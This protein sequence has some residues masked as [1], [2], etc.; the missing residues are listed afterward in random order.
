MSMIFE[1]LLID[2]IDRYLL[3]QSPAQCC[4]FNDEI[5]EGGCRWNSM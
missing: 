5:V 2:D 4:R 1:V 3:M